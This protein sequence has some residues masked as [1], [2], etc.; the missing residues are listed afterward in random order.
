[1]RLFVAFILILHLS[2]I[3]SFICW[4][5]FSSHAILRFKLRWFSFCWRAIVLLF[6]QFVFLPIF[7]CL[8]SPFLL[9]L[10]LFLFVERLAERGFSVVFFPLQPPFCLQQSC[11]K[12]SFGK[13]HWNIFEIN[14]KMVSYLDCKS[15]S[16]IIAN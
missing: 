14:F 2:R 11:R 8:V 3:F 16:M 7:C 5:H 9:L 10:R 4:T 12:L 15:K 6:S 13:Y 1:M